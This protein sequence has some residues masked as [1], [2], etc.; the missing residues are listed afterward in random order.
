MKNLFTSKSILYY[1]SIEFMEES[2]VKTALLFWDKIYRIVPESYSPIDSDE[3]KAAVAEGFIENIQ[4][5]YDDLKTTA[6][7]FELFCTK[8]PFTPAGFESSNYEIN[9]HHE[10][11]DKRLQAIFASQYGSYDK[12][13]FYSVP[14]EI[15][16]GYMF[17][18]A[19]I[20]SK[21][22][23]ISRLTDNSDMFAAMAYFDVEGQFDE[24]LHDA[25]REEQYAQILINNLVPIDIDKLSMPQIVKLQHELS[26]HKQSFREGVTALCNKL[27][28]I[29][30][31]EFIKKEIADYIGQIEEANSSKESWLR[32]YSRNFRNAV[33]AV[34]VPTSMGVH[35]SLYGSTQD[36]Y[37][38]FNISES[39]WGGL[40][41]SMASAASATPRKQWM[42]S[43]ATY[44]LQ[45]RDAAESIDKAQINFANMP[46]LLDEFIND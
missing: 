34:G 28:N 30:D 29:E 13:G 8:L 12:Q 39:L 16:N 22:R 36:P 37:S 40:I 23:N 41:A 6:D 14:P 1:P 45:I 46:N 17:F 27:S 19:M 42:S 18:L 44:Y 2:W 43:E 24:V 7:Q 25:E 9:L 10:K 35:Y 21:R 4:L 31:S 5:S 3:I 38:L 26:K 11:M 32:R 20:A 33:L 15:A